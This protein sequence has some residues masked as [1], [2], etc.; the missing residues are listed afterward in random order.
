M[1]LWRF[2]PLDTLF[3]RDGQPFEVGESVTAA[4]RFPPSG[5]TLQ[6]AVRTAV[7][8]Y[9][10]VDLN[11]FA[12]AVAYG[13]DDP[14]LVA[15]V[16]LFLRTDADGIHLTGPFPMVG[17]QLLFPA[18]LDLFRAEGQYGLLRP[19]RPVATDLGPRVALPATDKKGLK[20]MEGRWVTADQMEGLLAG[21]TDH[22]PDTLWRACSEDGDQA[23]RSLADREQRIGIARSNLSRTALD[24]MFTTTSHVRL[25]PGGAIGAIVEGIPPE[26][27]P[28][29]P[30]AQHLG[31]EGRLAALSLV[32]PPP[33]PAAP[34][35]KPVGG[36]FRFRLILATPARFADGGWLPPGFAPNHSAERTCWEGEVAGLR[37]TI[38]SA[39][40]GKQVRLGGW[41][42]ARNQ[43]RP[44]RSYLPSGSVYFCEAE[45]D[46]AEAVVP[47]LHHR[48]IGEDQLH[49]FGHLMV[50]AWE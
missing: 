26:Y 49:G 28:A 25:R 45:A 46:Q 32:A 27:L 29:G 23:G 7:L 34:I 4:S 36:S 31:G 16:S 39:C 47:I 1:R 42:L 21:R 9:L 6:G 13:T 3:F 33:L 35:L 18:P 24:A 2:E 38:C 30:V 43:P 22:L 40:I 12:R 44:L 5:F 19:G 17:E 48:K 14:Q 10:G 20:V 37:F 8:Q 50:G 15:L 41:D 11:R